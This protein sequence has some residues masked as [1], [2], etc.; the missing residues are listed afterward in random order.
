MEPRFVPRG[1]V[2]DRP[3]VGP[4]VRGTFRADEDQALLPRRS[5]CQ[6]SSGASSAGKLTVRR[7]ARD[8]GLSGSKS[9]RSSSGVVSTIRISQR[10]RSMLARRRATQLD[11][12]HASEKMAL[13]VR[14]FR[15]TFGRLIDP[16]GRP[17]AFALGSYVGEVYRRS[18]L[19]G[20][21]AADGPGRTPCCLR[22]ARSA[23]VSRRTCSRPAFRRHPCLPGRVAGQIGN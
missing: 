10:S 2:P 19:P 17:F 14:H 6:A 21:D 7:P 16:S 11:P 23:P 15:R 18:V 12:A 3:E 22:R 4:A 9:P 8:F 5:R 13:P 1:G 20:P